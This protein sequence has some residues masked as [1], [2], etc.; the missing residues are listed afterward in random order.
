M[1]NTSFCIIFCALSDEMA[2]IPKKVVAMPEIHEKVVAMA[3]IIPKKVIA[4]AEL[5]KGSLKQKFFKKK[6]SL[7]LKFFIKKWS[8]WLNSKKKKKVV[9]MAEILTTR[10][11]LRLKFLKPWVHYG[12]PELSS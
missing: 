5:K 9:A 1:S 3:E 10:W 11:P 12:C 8:L 4:M 6:C 2:E 7:W